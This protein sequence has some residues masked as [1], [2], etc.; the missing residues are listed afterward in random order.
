MKLCLN[1][2]PPNPFLVGEM[3]IIRLEGTAA[4]IFFPV[5]FR[6]RITLNDGYFGEKRE[7]GGAQCPCFFLLLSF[8][9]QARGMLIFGS[10]VRRL[11]R[12]DYY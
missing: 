12:R 5:R 9:R 10:N 2:F 8:L 11:V 7:G 3:I 6:K 4:L 1:F